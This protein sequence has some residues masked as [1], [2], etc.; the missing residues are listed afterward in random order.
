MG[1]SLAFA[2][3]SALPARSALPSPLASASIGVPYSTVSAQSYPFGAVYNPSNGFVYIANR[4]SA[5]VTVLNGTAL[6]ANVA[7]SAVPQGG[8][9]DPTTHE[10]DISNYGSNTVTFID[11][12]NVNGTVA[13]G[14]NPTVGAYDDQSKE[15]YVPNY[16]SNNVTILKGTQVV[17]W[18]ALPAGSGPIAAVFDPADSDVYVSDYGSNSVSILSGTSVLKT[19]RVG[20]APG[21]LAYDAANQEVYVTGSQSNN[22]T[23]LQGLSVVAN[24]PLGYPVWGAAYDPSNQLVY[25]TD[26]GTNNVT[27]LLGTQV[28]GILPT[29]GSPLGA[30]YDETNGCLYVTNAGTGTVDLFT[31]SLLIGAMDA[32]PTGSPANSTDLGQTVSLNASIQGNQSWG[33]QTSIRVSA[34]GLGCASNPTL[35]LSQGVVFDLCTPTVSGKYTATLVVNATDRLT[36]TSSISI[37]VF[38]RFTLGLPVATEGSHRGVGGTDLGLS[39]TWNLTPLGGTLQYT[40]V[41]WT[42]FPPGDCVG[43]AAPQPSCVFHKTG[44]V[45]VY[46][47]ATDTNGVTAYSAGLPF[48]IDGLPTVTTPVANR[49]TADVGQSIQ[50]TTKATGG[51]GGYTYQWSGVPA[52]CAKTS[53][54]VLDCAPTSVGLGI[55]SVSVQV[56][57][58]FGG[59]SPVSRA[60]GLA[61]FTDPHAQTPVP[62]PQQV[63]TGELFTITVNVSG[64]VPNNETIQWEG[65]P[66]GCS[67]SQPIGTTA[68]CRT[69]YPGTYLVF[70]TVTDGDQFQVNSP[71]IQIIVTGN[72]ITNQTPGGTGPTVL[73]VP[74]SE[75]YVGLGVVLLLLVVAGAAIALRSRRNPPS[76]APGP[77]EESPEPELPAEPVEE[78]TP[79]ESPLVET[80]PPSEP[81]AA[82]W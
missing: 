74:A 61:V 77:P 31:T 51:S 69:N 53:V 34:V 23:T 19:I 24:T 64:G 37:T 15:V 3:G 22:V 47:T 10:V 78:T 73:G 75:F 29:E 8:T 48:S 27:A 67:Y 41:S 4:N 14:R 76:E 62:S 12:I 42:G 35:T 38:P 16:G 54:P 36:V 80:D 56:T 57:D 63:S 68:T 17:G 44:T 25:L 30:V 45:N 13:V 59:S 55:F 40:S 6:V 58:S 60:V 32:S 82:E 49:T 7:V 28:Q 2:I 43:T 79:D 72:A 11:G 18:V 39:V 20:I 26:N 9:Y 21:D 81:D 46:V 66:S 1:P 71:K 33:F 65:V 5:S 50:F 70:V 52:S